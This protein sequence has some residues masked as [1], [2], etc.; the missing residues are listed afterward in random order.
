MNI[1]EVMKKNSETGFDQNFLDISIGL[2][3]KI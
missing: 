1:L 3:N 2:K